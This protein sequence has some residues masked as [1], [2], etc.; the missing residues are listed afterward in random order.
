MA[1]RTVKN[2]GAYVL[3][4]RIF[5]EN[6]EKLEYAIPSHFFLLAYILRDLNLF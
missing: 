6:S 5:K 3:I 1:P 4:S 2:I